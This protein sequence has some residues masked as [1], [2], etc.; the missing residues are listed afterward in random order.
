MNGQMKKYKESLGK[1]P[2][3]IMPSQLPKVK[4]DM[5]GLVRYAREKGVEPICLTE[6]EKN[7]FMTPMVACTD[8][9]GMHKM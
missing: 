5:R 2:G 6:E 7:R 4:L 3:P 1:T 8:D 9:G